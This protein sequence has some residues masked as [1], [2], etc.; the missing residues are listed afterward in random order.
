MTIALV[1]KA[2]LALLVTLLLTAVARRSRASLRHAMFTALFAMLLLLPVVAFVVPARTVEVKVPEVLSVSPATAPS[3]TALP[4]GSAA[5]GGGAPLDMTVD[6]TVGTAIETTVEW[7]VLLQIIWLSGVA[8]LL[9]SLATGIAR[10][11]HWARNGEVWL[12]GTRL[13]VDVAVANDIRRAVLVV[14]SDHVMTPMTFGF[15]RQTIVLPM[16]A[17]HWADDEL[18]RAL[19]HELEHVRRDDWAVQLLGRVTLAL[20]WPHPLI[21]IAWRRFVLEAERACDD[22]VVRSFEPSSYASQLVALARRITSDRPVPALAMA[23]PSRLAERV[24]AI[25]DPRQRRGPHGRIASVL[26][27]AIVSGILLG[28]GPLRLVAA[29]ERLERIAED[30]LEAYRDAVVKAAES[31][32]I[33]VL[34]RLIGDGIDINTVYLGDGTPLLIA[35]RAGQ[36]DAVDWLLDHGADPNVASEGDGNALIAAASAGQ[37]EIARV[38]LDRGARIDEVVPGDENALI[39]A[40]AEGHE[41]VVRL[42]ID[43]GADV[44]ARV[45]A[46]DREWKTPLNQARQGGSEN[47]VAILRSAGARE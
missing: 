25:L 32:S 5:E 8:L 3:L 42:L 34:S 21:W 38:L 19:R 41:D 39:S 26:T 14:L 40:A 37:L 4:P 17:R 16:A 31:G 29:T 18:R 9:I 36:I 10:L 28:V 11:R 20:Y 33:R 45:W 43:R 15:R 2:T 30:D 6:T 12:D 1:L 13:A 23:S 46:D 35:A 24:T 27:V 7:H 44:N 47:I 22:A